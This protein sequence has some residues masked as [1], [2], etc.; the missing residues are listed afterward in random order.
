M[1]V[2]A[3]SDAGTSEVNNSLS[4]SDDPQ[5]QIATIDL[6]VDISG[7]CMVMFGAA[8]SAECECQE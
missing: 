1:Q 2:M 5:Q 6:E 3:D 4:K 8:G 7:Y